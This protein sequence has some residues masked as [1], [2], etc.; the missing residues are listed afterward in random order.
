VKKRPR[1][2]SNPYVH[3][4][5]LG[6]YPIIVFSPIDVKTKLKPSL[7]PE[8]VAQH[9]TKSLHQLAKEYGI[10]HEAVRR[11]LLGSTGS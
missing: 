7:W 5:D 1:G 9:K 11:A 8:L 6:L 4:F 10:S 2:D 3:Y